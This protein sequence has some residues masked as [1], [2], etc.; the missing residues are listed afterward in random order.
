MVMGD[1]CIFIHLFL[2]PENYLHIC[3]WFENKILAKNPVWRETTKDLGMLHN[4]AG[5]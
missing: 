1:K 5:E 4:N 2:I 3:S